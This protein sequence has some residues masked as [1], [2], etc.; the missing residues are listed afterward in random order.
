MKNSHFF[1]FAALSSALSFTMIQSATAQ[2]TPSAKLMLGS[3]KSWSD[4]FRKTIHSYKLHGR[5][6]TIK[7][8]VFTNGEKATDYDWFATKE[9]DQFLFRSEMQGKLTVSYDGKQWY[10]LNEKGG[11]PQFQLMT[12]SA[13]SGGQPLLGPLKQFSVYPFTVEEFL[14]TPW[15]IDD[16]Q[17]APRIPLYDLY[18]S[19]IKQI[20]LLGQ[21]T[22]AGRTCY[23]LYLDPKCH[24]I[25]PRL[26]SDVWLTTQGKYFIPW[27]LRDRTDNVGAVITLAEGQTYNA[28]WY[29]TGYLYRVEEQD[30]QKV[31]RTNG[32]YKITFPITEI[33]EAFPASAFQITPPPTAQKWVNDK[34]VDSAPAASPVAASDYRSLLRGGLL[35]VALVSAFLFVWSF[36]RH[37]ARQA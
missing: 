33:N 32:E 34:F 14:D 29:P 12:R 5:N 4:A 28:L 10:Y 8:M 36:R 20:T 17:T 11:A 15:I 24:P 1:A 25:R 7:Q 2:D 18:L 6:H 37:T 19:Y 9:R 26:P 35:A 13:Q 30:N 21:E 31:W 3:W 16:G 22:V 23:H 27:Q